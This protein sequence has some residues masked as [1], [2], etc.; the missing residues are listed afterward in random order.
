MAAHDAPASGF[1]IARWRLHS[2]RLAGATADDPASVVRDL[3]A[4]QAE[5]HPQA[6][7]AVACRCGAGSEA[8]IAGVYDE[9][10][11]LRT[12]VLRPTWHFVLPDDIGWLLDLTR[13]RVSRSFERQLEQEGIARRDWER[14]ASI[15]ADA[16][17]GQQH[18]TRGQLGVRLAD[19]GMEVTG[20]ALILLA[21]Y[22]ELHALICSGPRR[23]NDHTYALLVERAPATRRLEGD[24]ARAEIALRYFTGHGPATDRDLAYWATMTLRDVRTGLADVA[25]RLGS[26]QW[27]GSTYW[28]GQDRPAGDT[29][30]PRA[31][32]LQVLDEYYR[33]YQDSRALLDLAGLK[34][35]G[36]ESSTG[37]TIIDSQIVGDMSRV[38][39]P[40]TV[41]FRIRLLR[42]LDD[43]EEAAVHDAARRYGRYLGRAPVLRIT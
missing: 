42:P 41:T 34:A 8:A 29:I 33:G 25:D 16:L 13:P 39:E 7:W 24:E 18:L 30:A 1:E 9:G 37:M 10:A 23:D 5:N 36:R 11:M 2:Q 19:A 28:Y 32:L 27:Q 21:G 4:V 12:H 43:G 38:L 3:L 20:H 17:A 6:S 14:G 35:V 31:H 22:A 15:I 40:G 26:F